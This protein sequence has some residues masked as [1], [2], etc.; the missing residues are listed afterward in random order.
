MSGAEL[1]S[2][3]R[4]AVVT[5]S[6]TVVIPGGPARGLYIGGAGNIV[7]VFTDDSTCTFTGVPAGTVLPV[8]CKRVN[9][10]NTTA[11]SIVALF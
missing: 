1:K 8:Q 5:P 2:A 10:T 9:S 6:D 4:A 11:T 7:V 3:V